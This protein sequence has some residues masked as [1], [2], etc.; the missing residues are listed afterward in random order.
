M[1]VC[2]YIV[3]L[4]YDRI[5]ALQLIAWAKINPEQTA[6]QKGKSTLDQI[7]TLRAVMALAKRYKRSLFIVFFDL[8]KAFD[9]VSR[10][11]LLKCLIELGIG[12]CLLEALKAMYLCTRCVL[13]SAGKLSD[14]FH[15]YSGIKQG[16]P[17]S[18]I[19]F[20]IFMDDVI[21]A[22]KER[23]IDEFLIRNTH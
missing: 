18:V 14:I 15:T 1:L 20:I 12:A 8:S 13:K 4:L 5:I 22:L 23:C 3:I 2:K 21:D 10:V 11:H 6:F 17:S 7:F 19:L 16:A 9:K